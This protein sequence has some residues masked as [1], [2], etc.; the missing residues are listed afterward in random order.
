MKKK[1][2]I[3]AIVVAEDPT[4]YQER[5]VKPEKGKGRKERPRKKGWNNQDS[6]SFYFM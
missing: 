6:G 1:N 3:L 2:V 5:T 4:R